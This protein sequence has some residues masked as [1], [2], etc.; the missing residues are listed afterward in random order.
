MLEELRHLVLVAAHGTFTE[1]ARRAHLSQP[2]LSASIARLERAMGARLLHRGRGGTELSAAG[3]ALLPRARA[4]LAVVDEGRR[5]V[6][7]VAG[8]RAGEVRVGGGAT[9]CSFLLP[10][11][12]ARFRRDHPGIVIKLREA[13]AG[14]VHE[15]VAAGD[16]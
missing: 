12:L 15:A 8:L 11:I 5:A 9:V 14:P 3:A 10:P 6:A 7:E 2:A 1:A 16:L 13:L 4:A